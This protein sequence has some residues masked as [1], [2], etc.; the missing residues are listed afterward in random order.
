[1]EEQR[2][3]FRLQL[4]WLYAATTAPH[5]AADPQP[6]RL[7]VQAQAPTQPTA[8]VPEQRPP[9]QPVEIALSQPPPPP[10]QVPQRTEPYVP[11]QSHATQTPASSVPPSPTRGANKSNV[12]SQPAS[13]PRPTTQTRDAAQVKSLSRVATQLRA[14]SVPPKTINQTASQ[15]QSPSRLMPKGQLSLQ[16][17]SPLQT[18]GQVQPMAASVSRPTSPKKLPA[19]AQ[20]TPLLSSSNT[21]PVSTS[22]QQE[23]KPAVSLSLSQEL[24]PK[25]PTISKTVPKSG[26]QTPTE[27]TYQTGAVSAQSIHAS[28]LATNVEPISKA[29]QEKPAANEKSD[30]KSASADRPDLLSESEKRWK[31]IDGKKDIQELMKEEKTEGKNVA[32]EEM[33]KEEIK[34]TLTTSRSNGKQIKI[35]STTHPSV[36]NTPQQKPIITNRKWPT[37]HKEIREDISNFVDKLT[38]KQPTD[39]R[40][41][42]IITV[43]GDNRGATMHLCAE[44]AKKNGSVNIHR[45]YKPNPDEN[46]ETITDD[47][48]RSEGRESAKAMTKENQAT[49]VYT[50]NNTQSINNS[51]LLD[52]SVN[53]RS[54]GVELSFSH[55]PAENT[56]YSTKSEPLERRM[57]EFNITPAKN[58]TYE[59]TVKRRCLRGLF[60]ESSESDPD[61]PKKPRRHG[62]RYSCGE[63]SKDKDIGG[64]SEQ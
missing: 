9:F 3:Q 51:I 27:N 57:A 6:S 64:S 61:D 29:T 12:T 49:N 11:S 53:E 30:S 21:P 55:Q 42:S 59:P 48:G 1:M 46:P 50:N 54:P 10:A 44:S 26:N 2:Q 62:C 25:T 56:K 41:V 39:E 20:E 28:G 60:M 22:Q 52:S 16:P 35:V 18:E 5:P 58:L 38:A 19:M 17:F 33:K 36:R 31:E 43:A 13:P 23:P 24:E 32:E 7:P 37:L 34:Q 45:G 40:S 4:P 63:R 15:P 14:A 47:E 8:T